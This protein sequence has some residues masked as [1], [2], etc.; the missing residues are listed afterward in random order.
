MNLRGWYEIRYGMWDLA[1]PH[2]RPPGEG[3]H[4]RLSNDPDWSDPVPFP[5]IPGVLWPFH[6]GNVSPSL[7]RMGNDVMVLAYG[8]PAGLQV[9]F[10]PDGGGNHWE[11]LTLLG[12]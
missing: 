6:A 3:M 10:S 12:P 7:L 4:A 2:Y 11:T 9:A 8:R 5:G 1:P